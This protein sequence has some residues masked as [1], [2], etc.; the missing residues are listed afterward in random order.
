[1][2]KIRY[3]DEQKEEFAKEWIAS[4]QPIV[5]WFA[6]E[7]RPHINTMKQLAIVQEELERRK[8]NRGGRS[9]STQHRGAQGAPRSVMSPLRAQFEAEYEANKDAAYAVW[10]QTNQEAIKE[11]LVK[12]AEAELAAEIASLASAH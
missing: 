4:G 3:T 8:G 11:Q 7:D 10:L 5:A 6:E 2:A 9:T 12:K 1:M